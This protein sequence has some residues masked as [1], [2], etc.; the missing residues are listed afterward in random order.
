M[1]I[2]VDKAVIFVFVV[3]IVIICIEKLLQTDWL[4][5]SL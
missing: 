3:I 1:E 4:R 2:S 5:A